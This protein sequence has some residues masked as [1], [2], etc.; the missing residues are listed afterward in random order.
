MPD[1]HDRSILTGTDPA[2]RAARMALF[3]R[4]FILVIARAKKDG[5]ESDGVF[6][7]FLITMND[8]TFVMTAG[9]IIKRMHDEAGAGWTFENFT[10]MDVFGGG[11]HKEAVPLG[12]GLDDFAFAYEE[13]Q[14]S[15]IDVAC[16]E[17]PAFIVRQLEV[18][19]TVPVDATADMQELIDEPY[20]NLMLAGVPTETVARSADA[21]GRKLDVTLACL[22]AK[23]LAPEEASAA[24]KDGRYE[25]VYGLL[26]ADVRDHLESIEGTSGGPVFGLWY[27]ADGTK[28]R[29]TILG[30]QSGWNRATGQIAAWPIGYIVKIFP[31][32][33]P[34]PINCVRG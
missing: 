28:F 15:E 25:R 7:A 3:G 27:T 10:V 22:L 16:A 23:S 4:H 5:R 1:F 20:D 2:S 6:S 32:I 19:R 18:N 29:Y 21:R 13:N 8:R 9:H 24:L 31:E 17:L 30:I 33:H 14:R 12:L 26:G 34:E 11:P